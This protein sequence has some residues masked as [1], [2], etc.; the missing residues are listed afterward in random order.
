[1][2]KLANKGVAINFLSA[3]D[4]LDSVGELRHEFP[5]F[6]IDKIIMPITDKFSVRHDY[7]LKDFTVYLYK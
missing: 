3:K 6:V 2:Y 1:M 4:D 7:G 5:G